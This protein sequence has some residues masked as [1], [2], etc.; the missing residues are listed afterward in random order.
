MI[1]YE[2]RQITNENTTTYHV[3]VSVEHAVKDGMI[4]KI[5]DVEKLTNK[6]LKDLNKVL[7]QMNNSKNNV[8]L[9]WKLGDLIYNYTLQT[10]KL[11][12]ECV[13]LTKMLEE[14]MPK[15][16]FEHWRLRLKFREEYPDKKLIDTTV[17][18]E[19]Y[20]ELLCVNKKDRKHLEKMMSEGKIKT[21]MDMRMIRAKT[22]VNKKEKQIS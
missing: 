21:V 10:K 14:N 15:F 6:L 7:E 13:S 12:F 4:Q 20:H 22:K 17:P 1:P 3:A 9:N 18:F 16:K 8:L 5:K 19:M 2:I 11:G